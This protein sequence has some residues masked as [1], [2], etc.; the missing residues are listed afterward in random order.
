MALRFIQSLHDQYYGM[1]DF[2]RHQYLSVVKNVYSPT[3]QD[4]VT[5]AQG[6]NTRTSTQHTKNTGAHMAF[7][8]EDENNKNDQTTGS[9]Q[10]RGCGRRGGRGR[11][12]MGDR[13]WVE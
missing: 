5:M 1:C 3:L 6:W 13:D 9:W 2:L 7:Y 10:G 4:A 12:G 8:T 11:Q